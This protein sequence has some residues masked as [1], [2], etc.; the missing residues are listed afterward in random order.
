MHYPQHF[1]PTKD[2]LSQLAHNGDKEK[3]HVILKS[4]LM[5]K[6]VNQNTVE[7][8]SS[9][10]GCSVTHLLCTK[11]WGDRQKWHN[12]K[13]Q[14]ACGLQKAHT[15]DNS[16]VS[17]SAERR[18]KFYDTT[19]EENL[20]YTDRSAEA[21]GRRWQPSCGQI[22]WYFRWTSKAVIMEGL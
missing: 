21:S 16:G 15:A 10:D 22:S 13:S 11:H 2:G 1:S 12:P 4:V 9:R 20:N 8:P 18:T 5:G 6:T 3:L 14:L 17:A 19:E 7:H